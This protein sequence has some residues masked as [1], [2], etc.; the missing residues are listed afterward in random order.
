MPGFW[1]SYAAVVLAEAPVKTLLPP[2]G[3]MFVPAE[4]SL[5]IL[6]R[7]VP[8]VWPSSADIVLAEVPVS[9]LLSPSVLIEFGV[10]GLFPLSPPHCWLFVMFVPADDSLF[11]F[12]RNVPSVWPYYTYIVI[13]E[14]PVSTYRP[15]GVDGLFKLSHPP[16]C[17]FVML[18]YA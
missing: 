12:S 15:L 1:P 3:A 16:C 4:N 11:I 18:K 6:F 9:A 7:N 5:F 14:A 13:A 17:M 10:D 8:G 2:L